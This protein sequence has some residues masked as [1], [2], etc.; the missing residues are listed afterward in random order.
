MVRIMKARKSLKHVSLVQRRFQLSSR[1]KAVLV[2]DIK[3]NI[4]ILL[5][6]E[7]LSELMGEKDHNYL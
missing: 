6:K 7:Y 5:E 2:S 4:D 3:K 1:F